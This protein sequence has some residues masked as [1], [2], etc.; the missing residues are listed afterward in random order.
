VS[1]QLAGIGGG[2]G[3]RNACK[4]LVI[5]LEGRKEGRNLGALSMCKI[6]MGFNEVGHE[7]V[8]RIQLAKDGI[9]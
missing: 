9:Q 7:Y 6:N 4:I 1:E 8:D 2:A 3:L 5:I